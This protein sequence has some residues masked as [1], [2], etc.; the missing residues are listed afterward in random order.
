MDPSVHSRLQLPGRTD[1]TNQL[2]SVSLNDGNSNSFVGYKSGQKLPGTDN[3]FLGA[4]T[5]SSARAVTRSVLVGSAAGADADRVSDTVSIGYQSLRRTADVSA[6]VLVG[7]RAGE[8]LRRTTQ[9][10]AIGHKSMAALEQASQCVAIGALA[11][12]NASSLANVVVCGTG[13][14]AAAANLRDVVVAGHAAAGLAAN[15]RD[16]TIIGS[17]A[18]QRLQGVQNTIVGA[19]AA[20]N[21]LSQFSTVVGSGSMN[22]RGEEQVSLANC[23][24][25]GENIQFDNP[26]NTRVLRYADAVVIAQLAGTDVD[27]THAFLDP[28]TLFGPA[29]GRILY[30]V[31]ETR[32]G[33]PLATAERAVDIFCALSLLATSYTLDW[34][35]GVDEELNVVGTPQYRLRVTRPSAPTST[36][37]AATVS[38]EVDG[39]QIAHKS[40]SWSSVGIVGTLPN[41]IPYLD[42]SV[43]QRPEGLR[44]SGNL[45]SRGARLANVTNANVVVHNPSIAYQESAHSFLLENFASS[46]THPAVSYCQLSSPSADALAYTILQHDQ[47]VDSSKIAQTYGASHSKVSFVGN[48]ALVPQANSFYDI[49]FAPSGGGGA[50]TYDV[51]A[52]NT[53]VDMQATYRGTG[54]GTFGLSWLGA[55]VV[56]CSLGAGEAANVLT[57]RVFDAAAASTTGDLLNVSG[58]GMQALSAAAVESISG[59]ALPIDLTAVR[60]A[61]DEV[62]V[63]V[64]ITHDLEAPSE[65]FRVRLR[66]EGYGAGDYLARLPPSMLRDYTFTVLDASPATVATVQE[67]NSVTVFASESWTARGLLVDTESFRLTP[68]FANCVFL[69][70]NFTVANVEDRESVLLLSLGPARAPILRGTPTSLEFNTV[71]TDIKGVLTI[72]DA[73]DNNYLAFRGVSGDGLTEGVPKTYI[74]ERIY[75]PDTERSEL[76]LFKGDNP[77]GTGVLGPDRVRVL[78][79]EFRVDVPSGISQDTYVYPGTTFDSVGNA[80]VNTVLV[81]NALMTTIAAPLTLQLGPSAVP[82]HPSAMT[83]ELP[84]NNAL[85]VRVRGTD[86]LERTATLSLS[87]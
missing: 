73:G 58:A 30:K 51:G 75:E 76:L 45:F 55:Y 25:V 10:V 86:G 84:N 3:A 48:A 6:C 57:C 16:T 71:N 15:V 47:R 83:F 40:F 34:Y 14:A 18:A 35:A 44:V 53:R 17:R 78:A 70:S 31:E 12:A 28:Y 67:A 65:G 56:Q 66:L 36:H 26:L 59:A 82:S 63:G 32:S 8:L 79:A 54:P 33:T 9:C 37:I 61:A 85:V 87:F 7:S 64:A 43:G 21:C 49:Q 41:T 80:A 27:P 5:A 20:V 22:R 39:A 74:G 81:A 11:A 38:L 2:S 23:V 4:N 29:G 62:W 46:N 77:P 1:R 50:A 69:G 60:A 52:Y 72:G 68:A 19:R 24:V 13:V 42:L